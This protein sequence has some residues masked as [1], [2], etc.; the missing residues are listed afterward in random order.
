MTTA[1]LQS[2]LSY[3]GS[4]LVLVALFMVIYERVTPYPELRLIREGN[5]AAALTF[6]GAMLGFTLTF[7]SS[8][9]HSATFPQFVM[10]AGVGGLM[11]ILA[12]GLACLGVGNVK[13][14]ITS[15][16]NAVALGLFFISLTVGALNAAALS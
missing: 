12:F 15:G 5:T 13:E 6:G 7:V 9:M 1:L 3:F 8:A 14:H 11:Q 2:Y 16:N 10:W 4:G